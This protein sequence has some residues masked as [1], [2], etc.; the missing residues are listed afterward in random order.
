MSRVTSVQWIEIKLPAAGAVT[1][2]DGGKAETH[3]ERLKKLLRIHDMDPRPVFLYFHFGHEDVKKSS[4]LTPEGKASAKQCGV[5]AEAEF[6][7][8]GPL[9][10]CVEVNMDASDRATA[11]SLGI[12]AGPSYALVAHDL[13]VIAKSEDFT[14]G[15]AAATFIRS[16]LSTAKGFTDYWKALQ[17]RTEEQKTLLAQARD[18]VKQKKP[19]EALAT[20]DQIRFSELRIGE[21]FDEACAEAAKIEAQLAEKAEKKNKSK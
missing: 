4:D 12:G 6:T 19:E 7:R 17:T 13:S 8:W 18:L 21:F 10:R 16:T 11:E 2:A 9:V 3:E 14:N 5:M 20:Y 1:P 15:K